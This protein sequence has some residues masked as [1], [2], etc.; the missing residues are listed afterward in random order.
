M[1]REDPRDY[2]RCR[3]RVAPLQG[4]PGFHDSPCLEFLRLR[5]DLRKGILTTQPDDTPV[6]H[7][8][9]ATG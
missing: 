2:G 6:P 5:L 7:L 8:M 3:E 1:S 9:A 4:R